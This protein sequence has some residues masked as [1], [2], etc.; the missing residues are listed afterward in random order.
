MHQT[1]NSRYHRSFL[2]K[3]C[4]TP[5]RDNVWIN[6]VEK[7]TR[8]FRRCYVNRGK[9][10]PCRRMVIPLASSS[11]IKQRQLMSRSK[12]HEW[13]TKSQEQRGKS[14]IPTSVK[15]RCQEPRALTYEPITNIKS[16][17]PRA[18]C[19]EPHA[20]SHIPRA[21]CREPHA[22]SHMP[23]ATWREPHAESQEPAK[24]HEPRA[25]C[26]ESEP[27]SRHQEHF[28]TQSISG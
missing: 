22:E 7:C 1:Q 4:R 26:N 11:I 13:R 16:R 24:C 10:T 12:N 17:V 14:Q 23:R 6:P 8:Y 2:W 20:E 28:Q 15:C 3:I 5:V 21:T 9:V 19:R 25:R 27:T 18:T